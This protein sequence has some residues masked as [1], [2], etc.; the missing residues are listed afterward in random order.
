MEAQKN[1]LRHNLTY[2]KYSLKPML[3]LIVPVVLLMIQLSLWF[4]RYPLD[5][6]ES[7]VVKLKFKGQALFNENVVLRVPEG[8]TIET[9]PLRIQEEKAIY[10][11]IK[12]LSKGTY[13]LEFLLNPD[14]LTKTLVVD[15]RLARLSIKRVSSNLFQQLLYPA[16]KSFSRNSGSDY[17][18]IKYPSISYHF[19]G[20]QI[21]W[22]VIFFVVSILTGFLLKKFF[23]VEI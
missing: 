5:T 7:A 14:T 6:G 12:A 1:I 20:W 17:I 19:L 16:E 22:L 23:K 11:R 3:F 8:I 4:D 13:N 2:M 15:D 10:W 18:E 9:P 21:H